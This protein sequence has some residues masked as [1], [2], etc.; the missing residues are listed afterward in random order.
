MS[1]TQEERRDAEKRV[2]LYMPLTEKQGHY[3][4]AYHNNTGKRKCRTGNYPCGIIQMYDARGEDLLP[5]YSWDEVLRFEE[6]IGGRLPPFFR[7]YLLFVS[8]ETHYAKYRTYIHLRLESS[9]PHQDRIRK[10]NEKEEYDL[11]GTLERQGAPDDEYPDLLDGTIQVGDDG[12]EY[13]QYLVV[14]GESKGLVF[15]TDSSAFFRHREIG[16]IDDLL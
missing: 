8:R 2:Q 4:R 12:C 16:Y 1:F 13:S 6:E 3:L 11:W 15:E 14:R 7:T 5:P 9:R 10:M